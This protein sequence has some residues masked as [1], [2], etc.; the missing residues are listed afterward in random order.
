MEM[1]RIKRVPTIV[2]NFQKEEGEDGARRV[3]CG[4][5][6]L[7]KCCLQGT[8]LDAFFVLKLVLFCALKS[9]L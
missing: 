7:D 1:L 2:S 5:N 3:G 4:R 9:C 8:S 6:C